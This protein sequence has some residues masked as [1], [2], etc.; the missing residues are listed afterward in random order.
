MPSIL[1]KIVQSSK[2]HKF[3]FSYSY[4]CIYSAD[5][6]HKDFRSVIHEDFRMSVE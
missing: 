5:V 2:K 1:Y 4:S 6:M 3:I